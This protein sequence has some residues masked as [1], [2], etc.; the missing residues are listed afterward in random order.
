ML[1]KV[2]LRLQTAVQIDPCHLMAQSSQ[3]FL[4]KQAVQRGALCLLAET[5]VPAGA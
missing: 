1:S 3:G 5:R 4:W 2:E